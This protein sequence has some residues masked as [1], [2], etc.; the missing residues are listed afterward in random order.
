MTSGGGRPEPDYGKPTEIAL[1][2][3]YRAAKPKGTYRADYAGNSGTARH[4]HVRDRPVMHG[5]RR[6]RVK[7]RFL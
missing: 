4:K 6:K 1:K 2:H 5:S 3:K 7:A